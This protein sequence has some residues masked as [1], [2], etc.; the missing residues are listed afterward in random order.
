MWE[1]REELCRSCRRYYPNRSPLPLSTN[2]CYYRW[3]SRCQWND[4]QNGTSSPW[5][6]EVSVAHQPER[7]TLRLTKIKVYVNTLLTQEPWDEPIHC[8]QT[9]APPSAFYGRR[10]DLFYLTVAVAFIKNPYNLIIIKLS[11]LT[12]YN[13]CRL[14]CIGETKT[15][16]TFGLREVIAAAGRHT[17][18]RQRQQH[19]T[20]RRNVTGSLGTINSTTTRQSKRHS[21]GCSS[22]SVVS[23]GMYILKTQKKKT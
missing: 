10:T 7:N 1:G 2:P 16:T 15:K 18:G 4:I 6:K 8:A 20:V 23:G 3:T 17:L 9:S 14:L 12:Y 13:C 19:C 22:I 11:L 21:T 5:G